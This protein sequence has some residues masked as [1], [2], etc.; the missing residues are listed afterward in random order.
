MSTYVVFTPGA[1]VPLGAATLSIS[2][3]EADVVGFDALEVWKATSVSGP[4]LEMTGANW[5]GARLPSYGGD[6]PDTVVDGARVVVEDL[7]V[8][9]LVKEEELTVTFVSTEAVTLAAVAEAITAQGAGLVTAYVDSRGQLTLETALGGP[10]ATL[11]AV[12]GTATS[13]LGIPL[14]SISYGVAAWLSVPVGDSVQTFVD[15][16]S[17]TGTYYRTRLRN[18][19]TGAVGAFSDAVPA[20]NPSGLPANSLVLGT[21]DVV[22]LDG[23]PI[24][25]IEVTVYNKYSTLP[26]D[27]RLVVEGTVRM[28]TDS[29]GHAEVYLLRGAKVTVSISGTAITRDVTVPSDPTTSTFSLLGSEVG[30][31]DDAFRVQVPVLNYAARRSL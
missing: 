17:S 29:E 24:R 13:T 26:V 22:S 12:G 8:E 27:G 30:A 11:S 16:Y 14:D 10:S 7:T 31:Q 28:V 18:R 4:Y 19:A 9:L 2:L 15:P 25:N 3:G 21:I 1:D 5:R 6:L 20:N 23:K